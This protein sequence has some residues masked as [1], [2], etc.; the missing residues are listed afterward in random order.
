MS[1]SGEVRNPWGEAA[2]DAGVPLVDRAVAGREYG[3]DLAACRDDVQGAADTAV[4]AGRAGRGRPV[5]G[6]GPA[7][8]SG[9]GE[10]TGGAGVDATA[11]RHAVGLGPGPAGAGGDHG[12]GAPAG[13]GQGEGAL[14]LGA[15]AD[16]PA[17]G[18]AQVPV[19]PDVGVGVVPAPAAGA[20]CHVGG[21]SRRP[22]DLGQ[23]TGVVV[24]EGTGRQG[25]DDDLHRLPAQPP[26]LVG[27]G[28]DLYTG[29]GRGHTGRH[30]P[31]VGGHE[32]G[33]AGP[34]RG[35]PVVGAQRGQID[36]GRLH[37]REQGGPVGHGDARAVD[38]DLDS[39]HGAHPAS[40][41]P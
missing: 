26:E 29:A 35:D 27:A 4:S 37:R 41:S 32:A 9:F 13:Q 3:R 22:A 40:R 20:L 36:P 12:V 17:A 5:G 30:G 34:G 38:A 1:R 11:A 10:R 24:G 2:F 7:C 6:G 16:A 28:L 23:F 25:R 14:H 18:D 8:R 33:T 31:S 21:D 15:H 19:Q 39:G